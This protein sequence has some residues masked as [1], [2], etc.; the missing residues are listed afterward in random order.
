MDIFQIVGLGFIAATLGLIL[1][2]ERPEF[3]VQLGLAFAALI[4]LFILNKIGSVLEVFRELAAR[5]Q[6]NMLYVETLLKILAVAY[7][8][9]FG[10]QVCKDA[11]SGAVAGK[12]AFAGKI[13]V[14]VM[15]VP[16]IALA[17]DTMAKLIP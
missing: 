9:E 1:Q 4:F 10:V 17:L 5:A 2:K 12:I 14:M 6:V 7:V 11:G 8:T 13:I 15:A 16:I 3:A